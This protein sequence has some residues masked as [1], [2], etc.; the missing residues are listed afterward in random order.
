MLDE[1]MD[2]GIEIVELKKRRYDLTLEDVPPEVFPTV[3][4]VAQEHYNK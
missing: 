3:F 4:Q 1:S 2:E